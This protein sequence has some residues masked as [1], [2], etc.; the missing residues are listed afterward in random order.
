MK[1]NIDKNPENPLSLTEGYTEWTSPSNIALIKYWGKRYPQLPMNANLSMS[2]DSSFTKT[3]IRYARGKSKGLTW[4]FLFEGKEAPDFHPKIDKF[5]NAV[6]NK[7]SFLSEDIHLD[8]NSSN[9]FPHSSGIASSAS[10]MSALAL[11][12]VQIEE[13]FTGKKKDPQ[14]FLKSAS[15]IARMGSGSASRSLYPGYAIWGETDDIPDSSD[16]FAI[17]FNEEIHPF[18]QELMDYIHI[19]SSEKKSVS[20]TAGHELMDEHPYDL[21]VYGY[22]CCMSRRSAPSTDL[23]SS[24]DPSVRHLWYSCATTGARYAGTERPDCP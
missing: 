3:S 7:L 23:H 22:R 15:E 21:S 6:R 17:P 4:K 1:T 10:S 2:L 8:I 16:Y 19:V 18:F 24:A 20:S 9:T 11:C 12:L 5:L 13:R 14:D